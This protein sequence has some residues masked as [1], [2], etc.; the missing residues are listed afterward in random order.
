M[1]IIRSKQGILEKVSHSGSHISPYTLLYLNHCLSVVRRSSAS[2]ETMAA[3]FESAAACRSL[4]GSGTTEIFQVRSMNTNTE[5]P[6]YIKP[7]NN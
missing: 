4:N 7:A 6:I 3:S 1:Y 2:T 5:A